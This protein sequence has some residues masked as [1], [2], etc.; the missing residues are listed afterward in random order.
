MNA[1]AVI[2]SIVILASVVYAITSAQPARHVV[3][4]DL[5]LMTLELPQAPGMGSLTAYGVHPTKKVLAICRYDTEHGK[6]IVRCI[7]AG[8]TAR[9]GVMN[10]DF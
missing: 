3:S 9:K 2:L 6:I 8:T 1:K 4:Q 7:S 5:F 10:A